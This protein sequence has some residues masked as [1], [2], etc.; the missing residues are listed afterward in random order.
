MTRL[1]SW[2]KTTTSPPRKCRASPPWPNPLVLRPTAQRTGPPSDQE[3]AH[4]LNDTLAFMAENNYVAT[5]EVPGIPTLA[6]SPG[7]EAYGPAD[8]AAFRSGARARTE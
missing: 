3:R 8:G 1:R 5:S 6:K 7:A 4:E 2:L